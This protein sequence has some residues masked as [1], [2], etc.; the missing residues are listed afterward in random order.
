MKMNKSAVTFKTIIYGILQ[1]PIKHLFSILL[2]IMHAL[3]SVAI[4]IVLQKYLDYSVAVTENVSVVPVLI[5][6]GVLIWSMLSMLF[7]NYFYDLVSY[8]FQE[9]ISKKL[10]RKISTAPFEKFENANFLDDVQ[11]GKEGIQ[12]YSSL[13]ALVYMLLF[14]YIP[15]FVVLEFFYYTMSPRLV[16]IVLVTF[17][18][19]LLSQI[20][21]I[22]MYAKLE[23]KAIPL[24]RKHELYEKYSVDREFFKETRVSGASAY[25]SNLIK[26]NLNELASAKLHTE[27]KSA[28]LQMVLKIVTLSGMALSLVF[29]IGEFKNGKISVGAFAGVFQSL[30]LTLAYIDEI[31]QFHFG[32]LSKKMGKIRNYNLASSNEYET[33]KIKDSASEKIIFENVSYCY[34]EKEVPALRNISFSVKAGESVAVVGYNGAGKSTLAKMLLGLIQPSSGKVSF[35]SSL[36]MDDVLS[37]SVLFQDFQKYKM[38][39]SE[40]VGIGNNFET[41]SLNIMM[42]LEKAGVDVAS[43]SNGTDTLLAPEFGG[44][45]VSGGQ[46]QRLG[47]A[48]A[49]SKN[50][51]LLVLDEPTSAIDPLEETRLYHLFKEMGEDKTMFVITHRIGAAQLADRIIVLDKGEIVEDGNHDALMAKGGLYY[52]MYHEQTKWYE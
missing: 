47:I 24:V 9:A 14:F 43:L 34:P 3:A 36:V 29:L 23:D 10:F 18:P 50:H 44:I 19:E 6:G 51:E 37:S 21:R 45:D 41:S 16:F 7:N 5:L 13:Y 27:F 2:C 33:L 42:L 8:D 22:R 31:V 1:N 15:Y 39:V 26:L 52:S 32:E 49:M 20:L 48:R 30:F 40:N 11:K 25:F 12:A 46:W 28:I 17:I 35:P 38:T 4:T